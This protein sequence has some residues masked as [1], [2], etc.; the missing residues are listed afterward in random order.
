V[1]LA[2]RFSRPIQKFSIQVT[3]TVSVYKMYNSLRFLLWTLVLPFPG[4][5]T[6]QT[7]NEHEF[8]RQR[9]LSVGIIIYPG[10]EPLD[11]FGPLQL[12]FTVNTS[13]QAQ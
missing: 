8:N 3:S 7:L 9:T 12:L 4:L 2:S 1:S 5:V 6:G 13:K 10:W 11:V